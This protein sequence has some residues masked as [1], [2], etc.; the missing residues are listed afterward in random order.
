MGEFPEGG[1]D[2]RVGFIIF[3]ATNGTVELDVGIILQ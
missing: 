2:W 1:W 3:N